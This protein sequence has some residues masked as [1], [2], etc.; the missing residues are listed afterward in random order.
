M[1]NPIICDHIRKEIKR[2]EGNASVYERDA[3]DAFKRYRELR[4][5]VRECRNRI[6]L[7]K[8][9]LKGFGCEEVRR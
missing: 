5:N 3:A 9:A 6:R 7:L 8:S 4:A 1:S 2:L